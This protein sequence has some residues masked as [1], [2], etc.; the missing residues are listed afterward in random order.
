MRFRST[1][2]MFSVLGYT[3]LVLGSSEPNNAKL[4]PEQQAMIHEFTVETEGHAALRVPAVTRATLLDPEFLKEFPELRFASD[5]VHDVTHGMG[6]HDRMKLVKGDQ[7][8]AEYK[9]LGVQLPKGYQDL[10]EAVGSFLGQ[11]KNKMPA[12]VKSKFFAVLDQLNKGD[13]GTMEQTWKDLKFN[14]AQRKKLKLLEF[15]IDRN[16][17]FQAKKHKEIDQEFGKRMESTSEFMI[18]LRDKNEG[19][20]FG[21][22]PKEYDEAIRLAK[23]LERRDDIWK[24]ATVG[25]SESAYAR[26][27]KLYPNVSYEQLQS[28]YVTGKSSSGIPLDVACRALRYGR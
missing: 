5:R 28:K 26:L 9:K 11:D 17:R 14:E 24:K 23:F 21:F 2:I 3:T 1:L 18:K 4:T 7:A 16:D 20:S 19:V 27:R 12:D 25:M 10:N 13:D 8:A 6:N 15:V 22:T